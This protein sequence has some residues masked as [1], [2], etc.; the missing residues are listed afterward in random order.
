VVNWP[1]LLISAYGE[2]SDHVVEAVTFALLLS[3]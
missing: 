3:S 2:S 1:L